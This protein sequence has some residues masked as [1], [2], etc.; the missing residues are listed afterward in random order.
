MY[1]VSLQ[2]LAALQLPCCSHALMFQRHLP[3]CA[4]EKWAAAIATTM[5]ERGTITQPELDAA[6]GKPTDEPPVMYVPV[7]AQQACLLHHAL[8]LDQNPH[9]SPSHLFAA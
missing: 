1:A 3:A 7:P 6:L 8:A 2:D 9:C 5:I 4:D